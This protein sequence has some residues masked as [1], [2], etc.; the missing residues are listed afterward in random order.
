MRET[1][2]SPRNRALQALLRDLRN[3]KGLTQKDV[4]NRLTRPQSFVAKYESGERGLS[5]VEFI[6]VT[7][8]LDVEPAKTL[9]KL[10]ALIDPPA[11]T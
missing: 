10:L 6:D 1:L 2:R 4:A 7:R 9:Q 11:R 8:A 5:V 3:S